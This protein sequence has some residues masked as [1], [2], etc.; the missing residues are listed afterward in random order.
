[1]RFIQDYMRQVVRVK[2]KFPFAT[3]HVNGKSYI[4]SRIEHLLMVYELWQL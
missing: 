2:D 1:M 4:D 3:K